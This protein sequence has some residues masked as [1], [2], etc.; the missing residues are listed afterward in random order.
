MA[1][2][3]PLYGCR[4]TACYEYA[5]NRFQK[6]EYR[7]SKSL[8]T[9]TS[10]S[11]AISSFHDF[12]DVENEKKFAQLR[13]PYRH[14][15]I[16]STSASISRGNAQERAVQ[17]SSGNNGQ[18]YSSCGPTTRLFGLD[19]V[20]TAENEGSKVLVGLSGHSHFLSAGKNSRFEL[21]RNQRKNRAGAGP[22]GAAPLLD[23][24]VQYKRD[25]RSTSA[26]RRRRAKATAR[27]PPASRVCCSPTHRFNGC[28]S[29]REAQLSCCSFPTP[30]P[31]SCRS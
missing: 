31:T 29:R 11:Y 10:G 16:S 24:R 30:D 7:L 14:A 25:P 8:L 23:R 18:L 26:T 22:T 13:G 15:Q 19:L 28:A 6:N 27:R 21:Q 1:W 12:L 9:L 2:R 3:A 17:F 20:R 4:Q 5:D